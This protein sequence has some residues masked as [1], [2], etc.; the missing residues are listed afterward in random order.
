M[1]ILIQACGAD[2][3]AH[4]AKVRLGSGRIEACLS[5]HVNQLSPQCVSTYNQVVASL[6]ARAAAQAA[7]PDLCQ[8][9]SERLCSDFRE[10]RARIARCL[11]RAD[12]VRKVS[13]RCNQAI[14]DAGWR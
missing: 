2:V 12:N 13:K 9:D 8:R 14:T 7:A 3:E 10:G 11:T 1:G 4:C 6:Q 5:E